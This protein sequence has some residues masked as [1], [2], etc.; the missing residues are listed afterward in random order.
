MYLCILIN[1]IFDKK[2]NIDTVSERKK[3]GWAIIILLLVLEFYGIINFIAIIMIKIINKHLKINKVFAP[4]IEKKES[5][6]II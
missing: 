1:A 5:A 4:K 3:I 6:K 2:T